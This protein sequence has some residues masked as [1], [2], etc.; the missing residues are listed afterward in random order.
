MSDMEKIRAR[1]RD[2]ATLEAAGALASLVTARANVR[3]MVR[4]REQALRS[5][6]STAKIYHLR[7]LAGELAKATEGIAPCRAGCSH[8][9]HMPTLISVPEARLIASET[10]RKLTMPAKFNQFS[11]YKERFEGVPCVFLQDNRCQV[12]ASR[13]FACRIHYS[14]DRDNTLCEVH[15]GLEIR[16]PSLNVNDYD[17]TYCEALGPAIIMQFADIREFFGPTK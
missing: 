12:Y 1:E 11:S 4:L 6:S 14:L 8:C 15:P 7:E 5:R 17:A 13:P 3:E 2:P 10:G 9:C 16:S